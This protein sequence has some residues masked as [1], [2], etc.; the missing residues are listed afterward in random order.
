MICF[1]VSIPSSSFRVDGL[2]SAP[3]QDRWA[4]IRLAGDSILSRTAAR[5]TSPAAG[6]PRLRGS[7][8]RQLR[9]L[10]H[11]GPAPMPDRQGPIRAGPRLAGE[12]RRLRRRPSAA[13]IE[14]TSVRRWA[15]PWSGRARSACGGLPGR[16]AD[17]GGHSHVQ[18]TSAAP[19]RGIE[20]TRMQSQ[21]PRRAPAL[22][23]SGPGWREM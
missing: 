7:G 19:C 16:E 12:V 22:G 17:P 3:I 21:P 6:P 11:G 20:P 2:Q 10:A 15:G 14:G 9:A 23:A 4:G 8:R 1:K 18:V 5:P 13:V